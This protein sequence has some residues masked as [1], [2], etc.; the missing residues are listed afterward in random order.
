MEYRR[1]EKD[2]THIKGTAFDPDNGGRIIN[3]PD[4]NYNNGVAK[5]TA[6][7]QRFKDVVR[8]LK[9]LRNK[10]DDEKIA[11]AGPIPSFLIECLV[12]NA[13]NPCF[14]HD[15]YTADVRE[16]LVHL[17]NDTIKFDN[18]KEWGEI[19]ELKYLF[20]SVQ[21]WTVTQAHAFLSAAWHYL[22]FE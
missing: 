14:G 13:P 21:P 22:G 1:H 8:I 12:W 6:T 7:G 2:K 3:W 20:R 11:A 4:Q 17:F 16:T 15:T 19:N 10:M 9:R 18:C 5:N